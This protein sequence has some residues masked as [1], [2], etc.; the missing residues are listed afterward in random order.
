MPDCRPF[1]AR[2]GDRVDRMQRSPGVVVAYPCGCWLS[3]SEA[4][5]VWLAG[6]ALKAAAEERAAEAM[7]VS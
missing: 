7:L 2:C 5:A 4:N 1:C 3:R 6:Q